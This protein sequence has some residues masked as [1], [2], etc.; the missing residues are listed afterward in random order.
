MSRVAPAHIAAVVAGQG[1]GSFTGVRIGLATAKGIAQGLRVPLV[2]VP[3][4]DAIAWASC[5]REGVVAVVGDAMR[6]EVYPAR[7]RTDGRTAARVEASFSVAAPQTV[8]ATWAAEGA[9]TLALAGNGLAKYLD[10]FTD[11]LGDRALV[12]PEESWRPSAWELLASA[13]GGL[14]AAF[15]DPATGDP[16]SALP[17]Y[18]RLSD[19]EEAEAARSGRA[20]GSAVPDSGVVGPAEGDGGGDRA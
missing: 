12:L 15:A 18:T 2:T 9:G 3:T 13:R 17:I 8:A 14:V 11:A 20:A 19:A 6:G 16:A 5:A 1:P 10:V 4:L 7:Y